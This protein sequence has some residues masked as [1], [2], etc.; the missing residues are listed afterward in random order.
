MAD[1]KTIILIDGSSL[2]FRMFYA[3]MR[4]NMKAKD[5]TPTYAVHGF[6]TAIF[7]LI[8]KQKPDMLAVCFDLD[9]PTF[10]HNEFAYY[11]ANRDAMPDD[12]AR[13]WPLIKEGVQTLEIPLYELAGYEADDVIG[14]LAKKAEREGARVLILTGDQDAFQ[15]IEGE[16]EL[17]KVL[18]P[19]DGVLLNYDRHKVFEKLNV[20]PEQIIDYKGLSG[21]S[22]DNIPGVKGI[23]P[24]TASQLLADYGTIDGIYENL[25]K[26]K[27]A[28][29]KQ[30]LTDGRQSAMDSRRLATIKLD[31]PMEF[32]FAHCHLTMP[33]LY[34]TK[35]YFTRMNFKQLTA[36]LPRILARF[37]EDGVAPDMASIVLEGEVAATGSSGSSGSHGL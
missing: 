22:S 23:G 33:D 18:M 25:D 14:T 32:D 30:K 24:K 36:R 26:I 4:T 3:L 16:S 20:W 17:V 5:G 15:L 29:V 10:R 7:D 12:L 6:F 11:K 13:Q 9:E 2:A 31:V 37:S 1:E 27:S 28:S 35:E 34:K 21:D 8:E 19:K